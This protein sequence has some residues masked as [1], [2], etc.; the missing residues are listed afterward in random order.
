MHYTKKWQSIV[1]YYDEDG[2]Q[3]EL[4]TNKEINEYLIIKTYKDTDYDNFK[5]TYRKI[6]RKKPIQLKL[7]GDS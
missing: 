1:E 6:V 4:R 5:I 7:Y 2:S 3:L